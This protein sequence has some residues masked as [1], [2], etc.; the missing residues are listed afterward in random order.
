M[1]T[2]MRAVFTSPEFTAAGNYRALLKSP[3][4]FMVHAANALGETGLS[5]VV[6]AAG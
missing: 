4:E 2:L 1:K 6:V 5:K 3:T